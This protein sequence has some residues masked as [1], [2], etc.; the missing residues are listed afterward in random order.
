MSNNNPKT[1]SVL[2]N[3]GVLILVGCCVSSVLGSIPQMMGCP[4]TVEEKKDGESSTCK[5][6]QNISGII[7]CLVCWFVILKLFQVI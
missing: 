1:S 5:I 7:C 6:V 4:S 3:P 2:S